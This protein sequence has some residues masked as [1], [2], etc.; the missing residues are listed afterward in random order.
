MSSFEEYLQLAKYR[1]LWITTFTRSSTDNL[2]SD[3]SGRDGIAYGV[4]LQ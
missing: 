1:L 3:G 4:K 2:S